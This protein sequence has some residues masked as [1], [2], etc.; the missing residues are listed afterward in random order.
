MNFLLIYIIYGRKKIKYECCRKSACH[1]WLCFYGQRGVILTTWFNTNTLP[2]KIIYSE[3]INLFTG[4]PE[5]YPHK[6]FS[7][8]KEK[9][10]SFKKDESLISLGDFV[11][12]LEKY[13]RAKSF[14]VRYWDSDSVV[15]VWLK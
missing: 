2:I 5:R 7:F 15:I 12:G 9:I 13:L 14:I 6:Y 10:D 8:N 1:N 4:C 3:A 11:G